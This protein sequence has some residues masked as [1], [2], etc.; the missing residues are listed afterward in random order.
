MTDRLTEARRCALGGNCPHV[1]GYACPLGS[2]CL[3]ALTGAEPSAAMPALRT[4]VRE[5]IPAAEVER[6]QGELAELTAERDGRQW[7]VESQL[8]VQRGHEATIREL[9]ARV[10]E[11]EQTLQDGTASDGY[12]THNELYEYRMLYN[13]H[14]ASGWLAAGIPVVKSWRHHDGEECFG[15][16]WFIVT[17]ELP[18]GQV[19]NHYQA[20]HWDLF[21]VPAVDLPPEWDGHTPA[22]AADRLRAAVSAAPPEPVPGR[23]SSLLAWGVH[24]LNEQPETAGGEQA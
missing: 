12:H 19:S 22:D 17:A 10:A 6:L 9:R 21:A 13:A 20:Q 2:N 15:G 16:G 24:L 4:Q 7:L 3:D 18:T 23:D 8:H 11:L 14:A 1:P 5:D